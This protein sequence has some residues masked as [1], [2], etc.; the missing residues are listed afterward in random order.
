MVSKP[1]KKFVL[2]SSRKNYKVEE[3]SGNIFKV[4]CHDFEALMQILTDKDRQIWDIEEI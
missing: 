2:E 1:T 3:M 4:R